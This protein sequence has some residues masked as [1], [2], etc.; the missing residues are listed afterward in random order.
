MEVRFVDNGPGKLSAKV[1]YSAES[2]FSVCT[3]ILMGERDAAILDTQWTLS[4]GTG[5]WQRY[6][7]QVKT[8]NTYM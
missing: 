2:G 6:L 4:N 3:V 7:K 5:L 1:F 8:S